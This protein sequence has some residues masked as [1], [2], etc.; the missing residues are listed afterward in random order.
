M[1]PENCS[2][3]SKRAQQFLDS[4]WQKLLTCCAWTMVVKI[5]K[6]LTRGKPF[7]RKVLK[8]F[9]TG[10]NFSATNQLIKAWH[11]VLIDGSLQHLKYDRL[12]EVVWLVSRTDHHILRSTSGLNNHAPSDRQMSDFFID[13]QHFHTRKTLPPPFLKNRMHYQPL[14]PVKHQSSFITSLFTREGSSPVLIP[15]FAE[16]RQKKRF[17][18]Q[19]LKTKRPNVNWDLS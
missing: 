15:C 12:Q 7:F 14:P 10:S 5:A 1:L 13:T 8:R 2:A 6:K 16:A 18:T 19:S 3:C 17:G 11:T 4:W 9:Q